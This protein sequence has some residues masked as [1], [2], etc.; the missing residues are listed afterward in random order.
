[1]ARPVFNTTVMEGL[2]DTICRDK[3]YIC[4]AICHV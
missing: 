2:I 4:E 3:I 1:M